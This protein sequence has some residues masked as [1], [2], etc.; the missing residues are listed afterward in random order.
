M[1]KSA[2]GQSLERLGK[3]IS[4]HKALGKNKEGI[5]VVLDLREKICDLQ[6]NV[7]CLQ[8]EVE[9]LKYRLLG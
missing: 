6:D 3:I 5:E 2:S 1:A 9:K 4:L 8:N 7:E